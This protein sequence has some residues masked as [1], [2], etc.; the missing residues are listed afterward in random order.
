MSE[1]LEGKIITL[2][3]HHVEKLLWENLLKTEGE[4][5]VEAADQGYSYSFYEKVLDVTEKLLKTDCRVIIVPGLDDLCSAC[6]SKEDLGCKIADKDKYQ[7]FVNQLGLAMNSLY[8]SRDLLEK[9]KQHA[10]KLYAETGDAGA[11]GRF[12]YLEYILKER[13]CLRVD[14]NID[15]NTGGN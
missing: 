1:Q 6:D 7:M 11:L 15:K 3:P 10:N 2:R 12:T 13:E 14:E 5:G 8:T 9:I 4:I